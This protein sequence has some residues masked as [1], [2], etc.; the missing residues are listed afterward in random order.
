MAQ[1]GNCLMIKYIKKHNVVISLILAVLGFGYA[2][3]EHYNPLSSSLNYYLKETFNVISFK[4]DVDNL[5]VFF[6]GENIKKN[7]LNLKIY[8]LRLRNDGDKE[9]EEPAYANEIPFGIE[10]LNGKIVS[11]NCN[12][13]SKYINQNIKARL[14]SNK[15]LLN[16]IIFEKN[17]FANIE[18][19]VIHKVNK[20][21]K[22]VALGKIA[23]IDNIEILETKEPSSGTFWEG[24]FYAFLVIGG[25]VVLFIAI[26]YLFYG[27][28]YLY[29]IIFEKIKKNRILS[30][31][32]Y[33][34]KKL[35][36]QKLAIVHIYEQ[37]DKKGFKKT[38]MLLLN[39]DIANKSYNEELLNKSTFQAFSKL[40]E[41]EKVNAD[42][43]DEEYESDIFFA[44]EVLI[45]DGLLTVKENND[46][47]IDSK[48]YEEVKNILNS[49]LI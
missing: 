48:F 19:L 43:K 3:Y 45:E 11:F 32:E 28:A 39:N 42:I 22:L 13:P 6:N 8:K 12:S 40:K 9:I 4:K 2:I 10:V 17:E 37:L 44:F 7:S 20:E 21:P 47:E 24:L 25:I 34:L 14:N 27:I 41:E 23:G 31:Y 46:I 26:G 30:Y 15:I 1:Q 33:P 16:K 5:E 36:P 38:M 49:E 29:D 35:S 18:I